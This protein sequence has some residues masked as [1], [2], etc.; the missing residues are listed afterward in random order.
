[1]VFDN[2]HITII[3][4]KN[5]IGSNLDPSHWTYRP[6]FKS[7]WKIDTQTLYNN[8]FL[9]LALIRADH[10]LVLV[11]LM[12]NPQPTRLDWVGRSWTHSWL[13]RL[14]SWMVWV[15]IRWWLVSNEAKNHKK[16]AKSLQIWR[17][18]TRSI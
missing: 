10:R 2:D 3:S 5:K 14:S 13:V 9:E 12:P 11:E 8:H 15:N 7:G 16:L 6:Y 18:L 1:M 17:V 4:S